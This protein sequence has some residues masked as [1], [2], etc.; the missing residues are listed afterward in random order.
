MASGLRT[1]I[2]SAERSRGTGPRATFPA[3]FFVWIEHSRGTGPRATV[4][5]S[6]VS[7]SQDRLILTRFTGVEGDPE[8]LRFILLQ[9]ISIA[10]ACPPR[11]DT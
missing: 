5:R 1:F 2:V 4:K 8:L 11:Y 3:T 6:L 7:V 9:T 10:G